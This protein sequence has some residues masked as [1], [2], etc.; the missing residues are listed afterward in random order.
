MGEKMPPHTDEKD[1]QHKTQSE[2]LN[3]NM[4][5]SQTP[6]SKGKTPHMPSDAPHDC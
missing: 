1:D 2:S 3:A 6:H 4:Q 5:A